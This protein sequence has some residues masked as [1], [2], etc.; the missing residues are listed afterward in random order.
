MGRD[1][2]HRGFVHRYRPD[3]PTASDWSGAKRRMAGLGVLFDVIYHFNVALRGLDALLRLLEGR[4][5]IDGLEPRR[6]EIIDPFDGTSMPI[7][8]CPIS[9][10]L[11]AN[12]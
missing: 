2:A 5:D 4:Q 3:A 9:A 12:K 10:G 1:Q 8:L 11:A 7:V 6:V